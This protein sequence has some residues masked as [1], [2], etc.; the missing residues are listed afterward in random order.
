MRYAI[1]ARVR[2]A[3][4]LRYIATGDSYRSLE[5]LSHI[6]RKTISKFVPE[7][8]NA[9]VDA[10]QCEYLKVRVF[11]PVV[12]THVVYAFFLDSYF[13]TRVVFDCK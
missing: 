4:T 8:L 9:I 10:L 12:F 11:Y 6:S 13:R 5:F 1:T 2:L 7:V 3:I